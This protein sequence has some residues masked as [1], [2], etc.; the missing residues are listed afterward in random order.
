MSEQRMQIRIGRDGKF[1]VD[2][3]QGCTGQQCEDLTKLLVEAVGKV[4]HQELKN[5][6][7]EQRPD[8]VEQ[9]TGE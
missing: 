8:F 5:E 6:Y 2:V 1:H 3:G 7:Y 9:E 4:E